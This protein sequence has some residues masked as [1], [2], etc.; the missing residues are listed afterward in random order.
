MFKFSLQSVL[1]IYNKW[2]DSSK[3]LNI[4][5]ILA[6]IEELQN[7]EL[8]IFVE[9]SYKSLNTETSLIVNHGCKLIFN[10]NMLKRPYKKK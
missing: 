4:L 10:E 9:I 7:C 8:T 2:F 6:L 3:T 5:I 1:L